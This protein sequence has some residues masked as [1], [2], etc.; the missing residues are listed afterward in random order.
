MLRASILAASAIFAGAGFMSGFLFTRPRTQVREPDANYVNCADMP[1]EVA[2]T[3]GGKSLKPRPGFEPNV[4][5]LH[6]G[7][8]GYSAVTLAN[9]GVDVFDIFN[10]EPTRGPS[11]RRPMAPLRL[12]FRA[13]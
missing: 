1:V 6:P 12:P 11:S 7:E 5:P 8:P 10:A 3:D 9:I 4:P 13:P 2:T